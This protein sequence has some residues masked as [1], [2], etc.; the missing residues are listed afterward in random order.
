MNLEERPV[1]IGENNTGKTSILDALKF[2]LLDLGPRRRT[3]FDTLDFHLSNPKSEPSSTKPIT[4]GI[5]FSERERG[6][7]DNGLTNRLG[8][9]GILQLRGNGIKYVDLCVTCRYDNLTRDFVQDWRFLGEGKKVLNG[10]PESALLQLRE[11]LQYY[12]LTALR[13]AGRHFDANGPFWRPFLKDSQISEKE[14]TEI[15]AKLHEVNNLI[16]SSHT[17]FEKVQNQLR[18]LQNLVL[19]AGGEAVSIDAVPSRMF[20]TLSRAQVQIGAITGA[21]IPLIRH[22]EGTQSIAVLMLFT[23][24]LESQSVRNVILAL[25]EPEAHLHPSAIHVLWN[26]IQRFASQ[27]LITT[28]SGE[29]LAEVDVHEIRRL[30]QTSEGIKV[31]QISETLLSDEEARKFGYHIQMTRGELLFARCWLLVEG[32]T[33]MWIYPAAAKALGYNLHKEGIRIIPYQQA[34]AGMF[35]KVASELGISWCCVGDD[36][37]NRSKV[38]NKLRDLLNGA[39]ETDRILFPYQNID[40]NLLQNGFNDVYERHMSLQNLK[41]I[42]KKSGEPGYWLEYYE[43]LPRRAKTRAAADIAV[44][45]EDSDSRSVTPEI[46][47]VIQKVVSLAKEG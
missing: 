12:Y 21:K 28:H 11:E 15:E 44:E 25:E 45:L 27:R 29:L 6:E 43:N 5:T 16:V 35:A 47:F 3:V 24:F 32:E 14:R 39:M 37:D 1:L 41:R 7:W 2:C 33:E 30:A 18:E 46:R 20:D 13:D 36:D 40:I 22:G 4:I 17:S 10:I 8:R 23:A 31:F 26:V 38:E 34:D 9:T 19:V 42:E